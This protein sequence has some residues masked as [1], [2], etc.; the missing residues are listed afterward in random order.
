MSNA[1]IPR[2]ELHSLSLPTQRMGGVNSRAERVR[3]IRNSKG[4]EMDIVT[5]ANDLAVFLTPLRPSLLK[6]GE[7]AVEELGKNFGVKT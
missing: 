2:I 4:I 7:K 6:G 1:W 3:W 5:V